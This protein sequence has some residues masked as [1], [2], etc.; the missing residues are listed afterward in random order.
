VICEQLKA[1]KDNFGISLNALTPAKIAEA[2]EAYNIL[3]GLDVSLTTVA[4][5]YLR[6]HKARTASVTFLTLCNQFLEAKAGRSSNLFTSLRH[7]RDRFPDLHERLVSDISHRDIEPLLAPISSGG[8]NAVMRYLS[9]VFNYGV[10]REYLAHNPIARLDFA[11]RPRREVVTIPNEQVAAM[12]NHAFENDLDL[13][14]FLVF[15]FF[16]GVRPNGELQELEWS[17]VELTGHENPA[18]VIRPEV[19]KTNRRR[20]VDLS[21]NAVA[22]IE[23]FRQ[24]GGKLEGRVSPFTPATLRKCRHANWTAAGIKAWPQQS[25]RHSYCSYWLA[26]HKDVNKLVLQSGHTSVDTMWRHYHRGTT[27]AEAKK[28]WEIIPLGE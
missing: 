20:F 19:S 10:K 14:P 26:M 8:R 7:T 16:A 3:E 18:L 9:A 25:M 5:D 4:R 24:R 12:L 15:G 2:A 11:E 23:A 1:R 21:P 27:E 28:F 6:A 13:L 17:D 22:W